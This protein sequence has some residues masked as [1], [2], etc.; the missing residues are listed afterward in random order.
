MGHGLYLCF[1]SFRLGLMDTRP[2]RASGVGGSLTQKQ[3]LI[4]SLNPVIMCKAIV[5]EPTELVLPEPQLFS[6][7]EEHGAPLRGAEFSAFHSGPRSER[8]LARKTVPEKWRFCRV[9]QRDHL[10]LRPHSRGQGASLS[11]REK[12]KQF[13]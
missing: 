4:C 8:V 2:Q 11:Y 9:A 5:S 1:R 13:S 10:E 3:P 7:K 6:L 12:I